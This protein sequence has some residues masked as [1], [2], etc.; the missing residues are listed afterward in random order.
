MA[1][2]SLSRFAAA[3]PD[4]A[5][6]MGLEASTGEGWSRTFAVQHDRRL[7]VQ[8]AT[9]P[10]VP[11]ALSFLAKGKGCALIQVRAILPASR[12]T[13]LD[14]GECCRA[15]CATACGAPP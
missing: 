11:A 4:V 15:P 1:L 2:E 9:L 5:V 13:A 7:V 12:E 8:Q 10:A 6:D 14:F 3:V